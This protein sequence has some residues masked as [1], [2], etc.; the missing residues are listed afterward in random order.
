MPFLWFSFHGLGERPSELDLVLTDRTIHELPIPIQDTL[1][2]SRGSSERAAR[3]G[4]PVLALHN[5]GPASRLVSR[6]SKSETPPLP[7][8]SRPENAS[9]ALRSGGLRGAVG[10]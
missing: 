6:D 1:P 5:T 10:R 7:R 8:L 3:Q 2:T 9:A 4:V